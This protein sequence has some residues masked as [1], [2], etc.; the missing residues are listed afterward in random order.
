MANPIA[1]MKNAFSFGI[2]VY[3]IVFGSVGLYSV[4]SY[5]TEIPLEWKIC[6]TL[7]VFFLLYLALVVI[8]LCRVFKKTLP[9]LPFVAS[10]AIQIVSFSWLGVHLVFNGGLVA[11]AVLINNITAFSFSFGADFAFENNAK[12]D[13]LSVN[14]IPIVLLIAYKNQMTKHAARV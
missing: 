10:Q 7:S 11:A 6:M 1:K 13:Y 9:Y 14:A 12:T 3:L 8:G 5:L 2:A 4:A